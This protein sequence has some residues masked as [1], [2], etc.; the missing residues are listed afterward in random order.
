MTILAVRV[1]KQKTEVGS[2]SNKA[3]LHNSLMQ[4]KNISFVLSDKSHAELFDSK[5]KEIAFKQYANPLDSTLCDNDGTYFYYSMG[6]LENIYVLV[7]DAE[8]NNQ[9]LSILFSDIT[10]CK[11]VNMQKILPRLNSDW[12]VQ[13][14]QEQAQEAL[15]EGKKALDNVVKRGSQ[16]EDLVAKTEELAAE[17]L[18][19]RSYRSYKKEFNQNKLLTKK[20][21]GTF[22]SFF[23]RTEPGANFEA[24]MPRRNLTL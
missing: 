15:T 5:T 17:Q 6:Y 9:T 23:Q 13:Q 4:L 24:I 21:A 11:L 10:S 8:I 2:C 18:S 7:S 19:V 22:L 14:V 3:S 20:V 16:I 12:K 1:F